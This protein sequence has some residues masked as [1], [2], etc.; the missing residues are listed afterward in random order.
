MEDLVWYC[1]SVCCFSLKNMFQLYFTMMFTTHALQKKLRKN[2]VQQK[3]WL[4]I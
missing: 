4:L 2:L 1:V 3:D